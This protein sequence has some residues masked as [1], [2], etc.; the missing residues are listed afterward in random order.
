MKNRKR[1]SVGVLP[2]ILAVTLLA[3]CGD[4]EER[5]GAAGGYDRN[6][7]KPI[8]TDAAF[9][10]I[11][12]NAVVGAAQTDGWAEDYDYYEDYEW[13][14]NRYEASATTSVKVPAADSDQ[15]ASGHKLIKNVSLNV[16]TKEFDVLMPALEGRVRELGGYI[17]NLET[18]NGSRYSGN[19]NN[20]YA[21]VTVRIPQ[22][23]LDDFV[24]SVSD[25]GNVVRRSD[26]VNDVT[27]TYVDTESRRNALKTEYNRL[28][29][30]MERAETLE[31]IL[32]LE[33]RL[34]TLRYQLEN[35][36]SQL[37]TMDNQVDYSTVRLTISEVQE[38]TPVEEE[39]EEEEEETVWERITEGFTDSLNEVKESFTDG[40]VGFMTSL[41][42]LLVWAVPLLIVVLVAVGLVRSRRKK[43][44]KPAAAGNKPEDSAN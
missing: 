42:H 14:N 26:S 11:Q 5:N 4:S 40:I 8:Y 20:R 25:I 17:E 13:D 34:T 37:R 3:G 29:E 1:F 27:M 36:E 41:P 18:Y 33:D 7:E 2:V 30:L 38:L 44:K 10:G 22:N 15:A 6:K 28:L 35:L 31:E 16:E 12:S 9:E 39:E 24:G 43:R 23:R 32:T 19:K 21:N